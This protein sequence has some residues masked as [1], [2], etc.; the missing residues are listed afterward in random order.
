M[1]LGLDAENAPLISAKS[2]IGIKDV[3]ENIV[4]L[5]PSPEGEEDAL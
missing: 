3:L 5:I 4:Q 1:F 2:G